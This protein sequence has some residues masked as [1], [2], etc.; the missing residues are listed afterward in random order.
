MKTIV[1]LETDLVKPY[2]DA[3]DLAEAQTMAI[4]GAHN[5]VPFPYFASSYTTNGITFTVNSDGTI[6]AN[7]TATALA[8]FDAI[9]GELYAP[10]SLDAGD[11]ILT[12]GLAAADY[13]NAYTAITLMHSDGTTEYNYADTSTNNNDFTMPS[14]STIKYFYLG[15]CIKAGATVSNLVFKPMIRLASDYDE[16]YRSYAPKNNNLLSY[17]ANGILGAKNLLPLNLEN[18]KSLNTA[19]TWS[20]NAYTQNGITYTVETN[21]Y[22]SVADIKVNG[23]S[24]AV[25]NDLVLHSG[26][27]TNFAG[28]LLTGN[29]G[30]DHTSIRAELIGSPYTNY[31]N[32]SGNGVIIKNGVGANCKIFIRVDPSTTVSNQIFKPMVRLANDSDPTF[33]PFAM[34]N[35]QLTNAFVRTSHNIPRIVPK[36]ITSYITDGSFWKRLAG[37][38]GYELYED[39]YVGDYIKMSRAISA[40]NQDSQYATTG[41]QYVTIAGIDMHYGDGNANALTYH[42]VDMVPGQGFEGIQHFGRKR[43]N[44]TNSCTGGYVGSE[45]FTDTIGAVVSAG[46]TA[47]GATINQQ[48]YAEFGAHLKTHNCLLTNSIVESGASATTGFNRFGTNTGCS[49]NWAWTPVQAVLMCEVEAYGSIVWSSSGYDTGNGNVQLPLFAHNKKALNNRSA[50]YWL[51][52]VASAAYF[53]LC[54]D[55][56]HADYGAASGASIYVR[57]RFILA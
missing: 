11:Y 43:M 22:G 31:G 16:T 47:T 14:P 17:A 2:I 25:N 23:T 13:S 39:I 3:K 29:P 33:R 15:C 35:L 28:K 27:L 7:G 4:L 54:N 36:D 34:T 50:Y 51:R 30:A 40:P 8:I 57:P 9:N 44:P 5:L 55:F 52:D 12:D 24:S 38:D 49:N 26:D 19:G 56:G 21:S 46:S 41:S 20:G 48:L 32:D 18:I 53:C 6:T 42:H 37:T 1:D 45:M 10:F